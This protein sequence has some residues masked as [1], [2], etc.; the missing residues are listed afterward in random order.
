MPSHI[1]SLLVVCCITLTAVGLA[2]EGAISPPGDVTEAAPS[3]PYLAEV[4]GNDVYIRSGPGTNFYTCGKLNKGDK[5]QVVSTQFGWSRIVPPGGCFSWVSMR[6]VSVSL[7]DHTSGAITGNDVRVYAGSEYR[8]PLRS[9]V[10]Q[11]KLGRGDKI[12]LL[13]DEKGDYCKIAPP[14]GAYLWV[15]SQY[16]K[17]LSTPVPVGPVTEAGPEPNE[18]S[19]VVVAVDLSVEAAKLKEY[20]QIAKEIEIERAKPLAEQD[21]SDIKKPLLD[22][23]ANKEAGKAARYADFVLKQVERFEL[24][25]TVNRQVREQSDQ[26]QQALRNIDAARATRL[27]K[28]KDL[29]RFAAVGQF[30][31][32]NIYGPAAQIKHYRIVDESGKTVCY[33]IPV[34][35]AIQQDLSGFLKRRVGLVGEVNPHRETAGALVRFTEIVLLRQPGSSSDNP[36]TS[37]R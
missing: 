22:I 36:P 8:E 23:A 6:Y 4:I 11:L 7:D 18:V 16:T 19:P 2:Q 9:D 37:D 26:L 33:A 32:S 30:Q 17:P 15:S 34:G 27:A 1:K 35:D 20:Q 10:Q 24:A 29:S 14:S 25:L 12:K 28:V 21:Y 31:A 5:V 13:D 3:L